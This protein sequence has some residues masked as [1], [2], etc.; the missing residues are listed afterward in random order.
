MA[1]SFPWASSLDS[2]F[3]FDFIVRELRQG[4]DR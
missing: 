4:D 1:W 2:D 3:S